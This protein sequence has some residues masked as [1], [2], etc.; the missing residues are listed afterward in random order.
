MP[1]RFLSCGFKASAT[2]VAPAY[3]VYRLIVPS[4]QGWLLSRECVIIGRGACSPHSSPRWAILCWGNSFAFCLVELFLSLQL[5]FEIVWIFV[6]FPCSCFSPLLEYHQRKKKWLVFFSFTLSELVVFSMIYLLK[7][8][9]N[10][11][12]NSSSL[13][14]TNSKIYWQWNRLCPWKKLRLKTKS[15]FCWE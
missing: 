7:N 9:H 5:S 14:F 1:R 2:P 11:W 8:S 10:E 13:I 4:Q 6:R 12:S 15:A 3:H